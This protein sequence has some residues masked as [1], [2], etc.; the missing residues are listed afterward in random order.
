MSPLSRREFLSQASQ[1]A[2]SW[3]LASLSTLAAEGNTGPDRSTPMPARLNDL[4]LHPIDLRDP[5]RLGV[6]HIYRG[7]I[8]RKRG[9]LPLV[10][11]GLS[12]K[13]PWA[14][15]EYWGSPHM[16]GRFLD[17]LAVSAPILALPADEEAVAGLRQLLHQSLDNSTGFAF[18]TL[19]DPQGRR[20]AA[21]HNCREVLLALTGLLRW[22]GCERSR[23]LARRLVRAIEAGTRETGTFPSTTLLETGWDASAPDQDH[24]NYN[25]GRLIGALVKYYRVT[26]DPVALDLAVRLADYNIAHTFTPEG[27][28]TGGAG[29]HLHSTEGTVTA[30]IDLGRLTHDAK[31][32]DLGKRLYDVGLRPWRT[33]FGWAKESRDG[34]PGRGE[35]NN[36]GDFIEAALLLG[37]AGHRQY[38]DD[39]ERFLRNG[40]LASQIVNTDWIAPPDGTADTDD[41]I[42]SDVR[43]RARG[44]FAFTTPNDY[45]SY[46]TDLV[47]G[48]VQSLCEAWEATVTGDQAGQHVNLLFS[49]DTAALSLRSWLPEDGRIEVTARQPGPLFVR[50]PAWVDRAAVKMS[51]NGAEQAPRLLRH[52]VFLPALRPADQVVLTF[53]QVRQ[54]TTEAAAGYPEPYRL[55]WVGDTVVD[56]APQGQIAR[57]Y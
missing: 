25:S 24:P 17:A 29:T 54:Q 5:I 14:R 45:N 15:H 2:V 53:P 9:C 43:E 21:M 33:S 37:Q 39:A 55:E 57:L 19:P 23:E 42:Y 3:H 28:L 56:I 27:E 20:T 26:Q 48:A 41:Y 35:A 13:T 51:V 22:R 30:I 1:A 7:A 38:F 31:Y 50:L 44:A 52:E 49:R 8:N 40:L 46:N 47:G 11:F 10:R 16:V 34:N 6:E 4:R 36:T 12:E 18:E 32:L